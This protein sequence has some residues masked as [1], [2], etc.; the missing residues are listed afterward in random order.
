[1]GVLGKDLKLDYL[2]HEALLVLVL[3]FT[4]TSG[5]DYFKQANPNPYTFIFCQL[6]KFYIFYMM[7]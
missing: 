6:H 2:F 7:E 1:M 4:Y 3:V 5:S